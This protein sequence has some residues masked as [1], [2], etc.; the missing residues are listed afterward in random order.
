VSE[1]RFF[2][3]HRVGGGEKEEKGLK[4]GKGKREKKREGKKAVSCDASS[5]PPK[6]EEEGRS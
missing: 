2:Y 6:E 4:L 3:L 1:K 5:P